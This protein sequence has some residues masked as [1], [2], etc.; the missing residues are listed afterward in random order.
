MKL[1]SKPSKIWKS[2][3]DLS[4]KYN[5]LN[6]QLNRLMVLD[7]VW[8][9][10]VGPKGKF[11]KLSAVKG[12]ILY[13]SVSLAVAKNELK[14]RQSMLLSEINKYFDKPWIEKIELVKDLGAIHE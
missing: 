4:K 10:L 11:W 9:Q 5:R 8:A 1:G 2:S 13:V 6:S 3:A 7:H 12:N 14:M